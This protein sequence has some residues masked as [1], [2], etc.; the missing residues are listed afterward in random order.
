MRIETGTDGR[1]IF[2]HRKTGCNF[3]WAQ[4]PVFLVLC[5][6][7]CIQ[8]PKTVKKTQCRPYGK[9]RKLK[10]SDGLPG[11]AVS[12]VTPDGNNLWVGG[13]GYIALVDPEQE[14][15]LT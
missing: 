3:I 4:E 10:S 5:G 1:L 9:S 6:R 7:P 12:A 13:L 8:R 15:I 2:S 14:K 11:T